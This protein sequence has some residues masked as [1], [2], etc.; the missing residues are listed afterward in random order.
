VAALAY[1]HING[2]SSKE[3]LE[4]YINKGEIIDNSM[5]FKDFVER[6]QRLQNIVSGTVVG[7]PLS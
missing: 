2:Y 4:D 5:G 3:D 1:V 6:G 7:E